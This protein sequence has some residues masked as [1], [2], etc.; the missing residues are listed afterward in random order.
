M[1]KQD[2]IEMRRIIFAFAVFLILSSPASAEPLKI[3]VSLPL[4]GPAATYGEDIKNILTVLR[5]LDSSPAYEFV[6]EDDK[7]DPKEAIT[8]AKRF[9]DIQKIKIAV[10]LPCSGTVLSTAPVYEQAKIVSISA[11]AGAASISKAGTYTFRT[12][13]SDEGAAELLAN[14]VVKSHSN[15]AV[16]AEDTEMPQGLAETFAAA[17]K[18]AKVAVFRENF[19]SGIPDLVPTL[20]K[21]RGKGIDG[22]VVFVQSEKSLLAVVKSLHSLKWKVPMF[23]SNL[24]GS[25]SFLKSAGEHAEGMIFSTL[26]SRDDISPE[27]GARI[28]ELVEEKTGPLKSVDYLVPVTHA[29]LYAAKEALSST[30]DV[31]T[32]LSKLSIPGLSGLYTFDK[33]GDLSGMDYVLKQIRKSKAITFK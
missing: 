7:C 26:P 23:S 1:P 19:A 10:G 4:T 12:R 30:D 22:I 17:A 33:N 27:Y 18:K 2:S 24:A 3:G 29:A 14:H 15:V 31:R 6:F 11:G 13:P 16:L 5:S 21:I 25:P 20:V 32:T 28:F 8:V 9:I